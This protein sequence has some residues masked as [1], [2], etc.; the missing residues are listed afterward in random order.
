[1]Y[2]FLT[3]SLTLGPTRLYLFRFDFIAGPVGP[4]PVAIM[5]HKASGINLNLILNG[6]PKDTDVNVLMDV[7]EKHAG[8]THVALEVP[9]IKEATDILNKA[10][11][12]I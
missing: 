5:I 2:L 12:E 11:I 1:M 4:E 6:T 10:E 7:P 9:D 8:I 3:Q